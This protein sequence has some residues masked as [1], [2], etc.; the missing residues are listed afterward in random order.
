MREE[1]TLL[2][3]RLAVRVFVC[4]KCGKEIVVKD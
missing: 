3:G 2:K 4:P 1:G